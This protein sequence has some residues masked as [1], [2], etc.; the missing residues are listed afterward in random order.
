MIVAIENS[1]MPPLGASV[2]NLIGSLLMLTEYP[3]QSAA[4]CGDIR[5]VCLVPS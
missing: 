3:L 5:F 4:A 2:T 1:L